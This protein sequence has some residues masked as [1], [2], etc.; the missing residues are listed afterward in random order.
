MGN[1]LDLCIN[2]SEYA[3]KQKKFVLCRSCDR[4][5][6]PDMVLPP[7][8]HDCKILDN[9]GYYEFEATST[10]L[11]YKDYHGRPEEGFS[12]HVPPKK[13]IIL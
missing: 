5:Y 10:L 7:I 13:C 2:R 11:S 8:C 4:H 6:V 1:L 9:D 3:E 12:P